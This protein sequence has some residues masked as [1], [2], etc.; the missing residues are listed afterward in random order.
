MFEE[1]RKI[2]SKLETI[3]GVQG[4]I[5]RVCG[6]QIQYILSFDDFQIFNEILKILPEGWSMNFVKQLK[7][8]L[9]YYPISEEEIERELEKNK[10][11]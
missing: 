11:P 4:V 10:F 3:S 5:F 7:L 8:A 1:F 6:N 9:V 2:K